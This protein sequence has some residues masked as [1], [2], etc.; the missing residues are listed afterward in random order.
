MRC[1]AK[2]CDHS[3]WALQGGGI[4]LAA[5][6]RPF[7]RQRR[8][9]RLLTQSLLYISHTGHLGHV[10]DGGLDTQ[11]HLFVADGA[12]HSVSLCLGPNT[13]R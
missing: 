10:L 2:L 12:W 7:G 1:S 4:L 5:H 11:D 6:D 3:T 8:S 9:Q 13:S